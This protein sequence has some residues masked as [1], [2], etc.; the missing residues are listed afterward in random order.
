MFTV[1][2]QVRPWLT[3][4]NAFANTTQPQEGAKV[5]IT[6]PGKAAT[7]PARKLLAALTKPKLI[8]KERIAARLA[9]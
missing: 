3:P 1:V 6:G 7:H 2:D 9:R 5:I 8:R 4:S